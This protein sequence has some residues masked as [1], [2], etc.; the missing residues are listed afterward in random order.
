MKRLSVTFA[1]TILAL[2]LPLMA[3]AQIL[4]K[5]DQTVYL[6]PK[7]SSGEDLLGCDPAKAPEKCWQL[8]PEKYDK[9]FPTQERKEKNPPTITTL[10]ACGF[11]DF[12][13]LFI[14]LANWGL[15]VLAVA[16]LFV[17]IWGG[18]GFIASGGNQ[19]KVREGKMTIWGGFLGV[20]I[21]LTS[22][23]LIGFIVSALTGAGGPVLFAG[24]SYERFFAG[25]RCPAYKA[26]SLNDLRYKYDP[27]TKKGVGCRDDTR[28]NND[29][30]TRAQKLLD[31]FG[32][33]QGDIDGCFGPKTDQAVRRF[34]EANKNLG[35]LSDLDGDGTLDPFVLEVDGVVGRKT[36][37]VLEFAVTGQQA[38]RGCAG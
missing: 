11:N 29:G 28:K 23:I 27:R 5:C 24:T 1:I 12:V 26:C 34:Q 4:P 13:Q 20:T 36:W 25:T 31:G 21:V 14:N 17:M 10:N 33:Y 18:Y 35:F 8:S 7:S 30:V 6:L 19:E 2:V 16:A 9:Q 37:K 3:S 32:C 15:G 22:W 38:A